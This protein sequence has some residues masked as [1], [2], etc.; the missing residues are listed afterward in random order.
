MSYIC[1]MDLKQKILKNAFDTFLQYGIKS[2]SMDDLSRNLGISKKTI[3]TIIENKKELV[4][5]SIQDYIV[6]DELEITEIVKNSEN[7]IDS[8][9]KIAKHVMSF[10]R[11]MK[12]SLIY[13]LKKY[14]PACWKMIE[15]QHFGFI[16]QVTK[17]NIIRGQKE[18]LY[19]T[20]IN[21]TIIAKLHSAM[22]HSISDEQVFP[23]DEFQRASLFEETIK[24]HMRGIVSDQGREMLKNL[25]IF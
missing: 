9:V 3:Y 12:P 2:V 11:K 18:G 14:Y 10:L 1:I 25:N 19:L 24:Y 17:N 22:S 15:E 21:P 4:E 13:D 7:A 6:K 5:T 8:M 20:E 23:L 16:Y